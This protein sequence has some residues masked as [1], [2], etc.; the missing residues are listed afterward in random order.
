MKQTPKQKPFGNI[1]LAI[2]LFIFLIVLSV[3]TLQGLLMY[4]YWKL[5]LQADVRMPQ[6]WRPIPLLFVLSAVFGM[7]ISYFASRVPLKPVRTLIS[8]INRLAEGDFHVRIDLDATQEFAKLSESF[9]RMAEELENTELL[10]SDF[11]NNFS[12]EFKT[13]IVSL[14]GFAKLLKSDTLTQEERNEYLDIIINESNRLSQLAT[15][16]LNLSKI[17]KIS[18]LTEHDT[19][20][21]SEEIRQ[22]ILL[23]ESKWQKKELELIIDMDEELTYYGNKS[24]LNQMWINLIDNAVKFSPEKGKIKI[25][26][27]RKDAYVFFQIWDNG[28]GMDE[29]TQKH[30]FDR[31]YQ[32]D[33]S[34]TTEGNGIGL[35]IVKKVAE[36]HKGNILVNSEAGIGTTFTVILPCLEG[37][38]GEIKSTSD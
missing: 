18:I 27:Y 31:F 9:N 3:M 30:I 7:I 22:A 5:W 38:D 11:I 13:P 1:T 29:N 33:A 37:P 10:R 12:H 4:L 8:A 16:V 24:L 25:K 34:H 6:F 21:L 19:F 35:S 15:N 20:D 32:G 36:L 2:T 17:E 23:L 26:L 28:Y 14:C